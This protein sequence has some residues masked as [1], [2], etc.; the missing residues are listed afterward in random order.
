[1]KQYPIWYV[2]NQFDFRINFYKI[3]PVIAIEWPTPTML[4]EERRKLTRTLRSRDTPSKKYNQ[5]RASVAPFDK[6]NRS[7]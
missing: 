1:M 6:T 3:Y 2:K 4:G 5:V 7:T